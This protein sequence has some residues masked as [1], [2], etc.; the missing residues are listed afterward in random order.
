MRAFFDGISTNNNKEKDLTRGMAFDQQVM[1]ERKKI[2]MDKENEGLPNAKFEIENDSGSDE[3][4][5]VQGEVMGS[6]S[7]EEEATAEHKPDCKQ[8]SSSDEEEPQPE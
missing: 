1:A 7:D 3:E 6:S 5:P 8:S 2:Q 4:A